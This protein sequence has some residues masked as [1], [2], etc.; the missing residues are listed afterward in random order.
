MPVRS[1]IDVQQTL[2]LLRDV[3]RIYDTKHH[4]V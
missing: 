2:E 1:P 3:H 4:V